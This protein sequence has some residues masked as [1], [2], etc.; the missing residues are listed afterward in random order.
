MTWR[1]KHLRVAGDSG[2]LSEGKIHTYHNDVV[3]RTRSS[4]WHRPHAQYRSHT[5]AVAT[6]IPC[7]QAMLPCWPGELFG[8]LR[9]RLVDSDSQLA[10]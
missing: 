7:M 6:P 8:R 5:T 4:A 9:W 1:A 3:E 10:Q 2:H